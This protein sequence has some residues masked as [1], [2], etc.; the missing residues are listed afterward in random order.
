[1]LSVH[2]EVLPLNCHTFQT[3]LSQSDNKK[4]SNIFSDLIVS[5]ETK[6][7]KKIVGNHAFFENTGH[8]IIS[9]NTMDADG[10]F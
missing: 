7:E 6:Y 9:Q 2:K 4:I 10:K 8:Y 3:G 1:M 5:T